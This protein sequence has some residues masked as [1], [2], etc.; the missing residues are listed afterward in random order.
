LRDFSRGQ[1][2]FWPLGKSQEM[3]IVCFAPDKKVILCTFKIILCTFRTRGTWYFYFL[4]ER[5]P[6]P[7]P[8]PEPGPERVRA[9]AT[10]KARARARTRE[11][12]RERKSAGGYIYKQLGQ[13]EKIAN[14]IWN[15]DILFN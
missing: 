9:T 6:E 11:R 12:E 2:P 7:E 5:E 13:N 1:T 10:A 4:W 15:T 3:P 8:E 14:Y